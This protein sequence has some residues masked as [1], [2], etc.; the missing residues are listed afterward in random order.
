MTHTDSDCAQL[1]RL[2][3]AYVAN[4]LDE[5]ASS[6]LEQH[7]AS[8][9]RCEAQLL[10]RTS[11]P[12]RA[13]ADAFAPAVPASLRD[14]T[15]AAVAAARDAR[16]RQLGRRMRWRIAMTTVTAIAAVVIVMVTRRA[17]RASTM[18]AG[19]RAPELATAQAP[20][21]AEDVAAPSAMSPTSVSTESVA[22]AMLRVAEQLADEQSRAE[23][24]VLD[25]A[26][27]ELEQALARTPGDVELRAYRSA[28]QA[29]RDELSRRVR[30]VTL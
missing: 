27:A 6:Q 11:A 26:A 17:P 3:S 7:A 24:L 16:A 2:L 21:V 19:E 22:A 25:A 29:R 4:T 15:L 20:R 13:L 18:V 12:A 9:A 8:C 1:D 28:V 5:R 23:F 14:D 30:D 10:L